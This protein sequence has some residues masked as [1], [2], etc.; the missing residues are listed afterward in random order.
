VRTKQ[1]FCQFAK[2]F[3]RPRRPRGSPLWHIVHHTWS[4]FQAGREATHRPVYG[5]LRRDVVSVVE[6]FYRCGDLAAGCVEAGDRRRQA[7]A[8][9]ATE[10]P[11]S[12]AF[13]WGGAIGAKRRWTE[14]SEVKRVEKA[15]PISSVISQLVGSDEFRTKTSREALRAPCGE[16]FRKVAD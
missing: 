3:N 16:P 2:D 8:R 11:L 7:G 5:P 12:P 14:R 4:D 10:P 13:Q 6:Q 9:V 1:A 15:N